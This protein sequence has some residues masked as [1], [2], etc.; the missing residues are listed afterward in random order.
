LLPWDYSSIFLLASWDLAAAWTYKKEV[1]PFTTK[2][3]VVSTPEESCCRWPPSQVT[4]WQ[5]GTTTSFTQYHEKYHSRKSTPFNISS[6]FKPLK[7]I[8]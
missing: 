5:S 7:D 3:L 6:G 1:I 8:N 2:L 4:S